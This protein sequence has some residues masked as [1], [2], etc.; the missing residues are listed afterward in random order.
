MKRRGLLLLLA[1][2]LVSSV[3]AVESR[4]QETDIREMQR[5]IKALTEEMEK[6]KLGAVAE[7][8]YESFMGLGPAASKVYGVEKGLSLGGYGELV[9]ENYLSGSKKDF[10]DALRFVLYGGYKFNDWIVMN[11]ELEFEHAGIKNVGASTSGVTPAVRSTR[12]AEVY[13]EFMYLDFL[14]SEQFNLRTGLM[15]MPVGLVNELHEPTVFNGVL[16]PD[17]ERNILPSTWRDIGIMGFGEFGNL[18]YKVALVNGLRADRFN[19]GDWI[20]GGRQQGAEIN[21]DVWAGLARLDYALADAFTVGGAY[22]LGR[23]GHGIGRDQ[24]PDPL[25]PEEKEATVSLWEVHADYQHKGL[26]LRGLYTQGS[27]DGNDAMRTTPPGNVGKE[28][29]GWYVEAGYDVMKLMKSDSEMPLTPFVRYEAYDTHK[30]VFTGT[31]DLTLDRTVITAG[32]GFKPHPQVV[33]KADYQA[34]DTASSL[35]AGK[36]TGLDENKIDQINVGMGFIF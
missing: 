17:V 5:Q 30:E 10:A 15:L 19:R 24:D 11:A 23:A 29:A 1:G 36:G 27:L 25:G 16:R 21:A 34:R 14:L 32:I 18:E 2:V 3:F 7:P 33:L 13:L 8:K 4:A 28:V 6:L 12:T 31:R 20:R 22:Y 26:Q 9:Y 35:P